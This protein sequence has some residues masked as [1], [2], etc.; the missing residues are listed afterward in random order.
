M[1]VGKYNVAEWSCYYNPVCRPGE[2]VAPVCMA[3]MHFSLS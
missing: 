3:V 2:H 1:R